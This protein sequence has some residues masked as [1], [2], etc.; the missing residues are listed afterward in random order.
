M[1]KSSRRGKY[2]PGST[3]ADTWWRS[4]LVRAGPTELIPLSHPP[5]RCDVFKSMLQPFEYIISVPFR[6]FMP[7]CRYYWTEYDEDDLVLQEEVR[8]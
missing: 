8:T 4:V 2:L 5:T 3:N 6:V 1:L 7:L